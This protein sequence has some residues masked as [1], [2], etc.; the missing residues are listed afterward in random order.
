MYSQVFVTFKNISVILEACKRY[1]RTRLLIMLPL[2]L[3]KLLLPC[4]TMLCLTSKTAT[5]T[6]EEL[7]HI[8]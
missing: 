2:E 8:L 5:A 3:L 6:A 7:G 4:S 1:S